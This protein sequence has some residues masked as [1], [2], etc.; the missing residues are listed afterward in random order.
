MSSEVVKSY[1]PFPWMTMAQTKHYFYKGCAHFYVAIALLEQT[2]SEDMDKLQAM[3]ES[4]YLG[5]ESQDEN[6]GLQIPQSEEER[7][8]LGKVHLHEAVL[9]HEEGLRVHDLCKQMRLTHFG[10]FYKKYTQGKLCFLF[11]MAGYCTS[12]VKMFTKICF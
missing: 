5:S 4:L 9:N 10:I 3:F 11:M 8:I 1:L 12:L 7:K 6:N 2:D